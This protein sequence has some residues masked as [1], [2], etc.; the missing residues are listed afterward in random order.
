MTILIIEDEGHIADLL[1]FNLDLEGYETITTD[2]GLEGLKIVQS[3]KID[4]III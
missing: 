4:L 2:H 3:R 1:K